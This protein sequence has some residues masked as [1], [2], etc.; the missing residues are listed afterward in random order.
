MTAKDAFYVKLFFSPVPWPYSCVM[1]PARRTHT[2]DDGIDGSVYIQY[3][4]QRNSWNW[5]SGHPT[6]TVKD[7]KEEDTE[8]KSK[9]NKTVG[10]RSLPLFSSLLPTSPQRHPE[11]RSCQAN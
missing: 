5:G 4:P 10:F 8:I 1:F 3:V 6:G 2:L 11:C 7:V 9:N